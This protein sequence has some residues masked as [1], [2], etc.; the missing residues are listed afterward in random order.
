M[1]DPR[2][3]FGWGDLA[4]VPELRARGDAAPESPPG[5]EAGATPALA[6]VYLLP[7]ELYC[8]TWPSL[9]STVLGSC[10]SV[11]LWDAEAGV[12]GMNHF[13]LPTSGH[14]SSPRFGDVATARLVDSLIR[15]GAHGPR[16]R[17]KVFGG[18]R[19]M[20]PVLAAETDEA[21][22]G[23]MNVLAA[24]SALRDA[25]IP[26]LAE[27]TLGSRGRRVLFLTHD[28]SAWSREI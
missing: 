14:T 28:G 2:V 21:S 16:L 3:Q 5:R 13:L 26:I 23:A 1:S 17:A 22:L 27:D 10:V 18:A 11:C 4:A 15:H 7:G 20:G 9:V 8:S 24:R 25:R 6:Q 12:G 19:L